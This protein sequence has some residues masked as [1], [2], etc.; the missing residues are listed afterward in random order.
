[1]L[2]SSEEASMRC[3][4]CG[5]ESVADA[6]FCGECAAPLTVYLGELAA[7]VRDRAMVSPGAV[8][9]LELAFHNGLGVGDPDGQVVQLVT[10]LKRRR[11]PDIRR[12]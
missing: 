4:A 6:S 10:P 2:A 9:K 7:A 8:K 1:V 11:L 3:P 12:A 5:V